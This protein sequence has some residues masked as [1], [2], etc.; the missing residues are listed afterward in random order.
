MIVPYLQIKDLTFFLQYGM[1][2]YNMSLFLPCADN[3]RFC[4]YFVFQIGQI[5][6]HLCIVQ[7]FQFRKFYPY[8]GSRK[9]IIME[10]ERKFL[11]TT[12]PENYEFFPCHEIEQA[13]LCTEPVKRT[14]PATSPTN[15]K[16]F[17]PERNII[18][19]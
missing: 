6:Y 15:P 8:T 5:H 2:Y 12:P 10:I 16:D 13:Y 18:S 9:E 17:S 19:H 7:N 14:I 3:N 11:V 4:R 1:I